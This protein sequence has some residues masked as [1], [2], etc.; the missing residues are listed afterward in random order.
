MRRKTSKGVVSCEPL[1]AAA[2]PGDGECVKEVEEVG[3]DGGDTGATPKLGRKRKRR[4]SKVRGSAK[5]RKKYN[6]EQQT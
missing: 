2:G 4:L 6:K 3:G 1:Q 5:K